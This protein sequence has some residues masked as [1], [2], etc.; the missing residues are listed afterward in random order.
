MIYVLL[1]ILII[2]LFI[3]TNKYE[4]FSN[5]NQ[6]NLIFNK[7]QYRNYVLKNQNSLYKLKV[8]NNEQDLSECFK[9]C[10]FSD[11][12]K[13]NYLKN[14]YEKCVSCQ[15]NSNKCFNNLKSGGVCDD[16]GENLN[17][18]DCQD[19]NYYACPN[20]NNIYNKKGVKPYYLEVIDDKKISTPY[21]QSCLFCWNL[22][23]YL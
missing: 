13:L 8:N 18:F 16:C 20:K 15:K 19:I 17:K 10:N 21:K 1:I 9:K 11:C 4:T 2:F 7:A 14:N 5:K 12:L 3:Y 23:N 22:K 6:S